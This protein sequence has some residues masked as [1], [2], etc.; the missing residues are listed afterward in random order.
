MKRRESCQCATDHT[1]LAVSR[2]APASYTN[3]DSSVDSNA[4]AV[5]SLHAS[6]W[7]PGRPSDWQWQDTRYS[8]NGPQTP[9]VIVFPAVKPRR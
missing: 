7:L 2:P 5:R 3:A 8:Q 1:R 4:V 9:T 6:I